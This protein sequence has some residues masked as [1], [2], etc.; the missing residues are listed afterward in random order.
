MRCSTASV[1][2]CS[3][4]CSRSIMRRR[5]SWR[6]LADATTSHQFFVA[7]TGFRWSSGSTTIWPLSSTS[8]CEVKLHR[9]WSTIASWSRTPDAPNFAPLTPAS[10]L[11][12]EQTLHLATGVSRL[13]VREVETVYPPH[14]G[15][16][17]LIRTF[18]ATFKGISVWRDRG[19]LVTLFS[20]RRVQSIYL[21]TYLLTYLLKSVIIL[22]N[23][24]AMQA[25]A[26]G[27]LMQCLI[28]S[29]IRLLKLSI[30]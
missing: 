5:A 23:S 16:L 28:K 14:C 27:Q 6:K 10:S 17:T 8:R 19:A 15:G 4:V 21:L 24:K 2:V 30:C 3:G 22:M 29:W 25:A 1:T 9:T 18:W 26:Y 13:W 11:F 7:C 20:M 12:R